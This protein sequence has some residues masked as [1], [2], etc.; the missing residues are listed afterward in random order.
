MHQLI[1]GRV[2]GGGGEEG[3]RRGEEGK[4]VITLAILFTQ[5]TFS[6]VRTFLLTSSA[7]EQ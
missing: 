3:G 2:A 4:V 1:C 7:S 5:Q 6:P